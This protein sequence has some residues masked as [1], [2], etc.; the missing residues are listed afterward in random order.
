MGLAACGGGG[1]G[2]GGGGSHLGATW[3]GDRMSLAVANALRSGD[4]DIVSSRDSLEEPS[5][6]PAPF[7]AMF[8]EPPQE[9]QPFITIRIDP[10]TDE[11]VLIDA[12]YPGDSIHHTYRASPDSYDEN[13]RVVASVK[14][15]LTPEFKAEHGFPNVI[16]GDPTHIKVLVNLEFGGLNAGLQYSEFGIWSQDHALYIGNTRIH[17]D[18]EN[19]AHGAAL[20]FGVTDDRFDGIP[21]DAEFTGQALGVFVTKAPDEDDW[22]GERLSGIARLEVTAGGQ[23]NL[24]AFGTTENPELT[25]INC[26][27]N[28]RAL[29]FRG[30]TFDG[31]TD[32]KTLFYGSG[33][34]TASEAVGVL[35]AT[36]SDH[37]LN[38]SFGATR[39]D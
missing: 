36:S 18:G 7:F 6:A 34:I 23:Q 25:C 31:W 26:A 4:V 1:G 3:E 22:T 20:A 13:G 33:G 27:S 24:T 28:L 16:P 2:G 10:E 17:N 5:P 12:F 19:Y 29:D 9:W 37:N 38:V 39:V 35:S 11:L 30:I 21:N 14:Y 8:S 15:E 32:F